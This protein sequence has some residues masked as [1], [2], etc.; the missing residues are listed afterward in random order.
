MENCRAKNIHY[1]VLPNVIQSSRGQFC[2]KK[3]ILSSYFQAYISSSNVLSS[4]KK[5]KRNDTDRPEARLCHYKRMSC[6]VFKLHLVDLFDICKLIR[7][8]REILSQID[9]FF[10]L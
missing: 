10:K 4:K 7:N 5:K 8:Q 2:V 1:L 3:H 9:L 6:Y